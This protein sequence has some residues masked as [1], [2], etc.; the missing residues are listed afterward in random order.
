[1]ELRNSK[2]AKWT[3]DGWT[4]RPRRGGG[5]G[6]HTRRARYLSA[7]LSAIAEGDGG[8]AWAEAGSVSR[9]SVRRIP[10]AAA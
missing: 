1:M 6:E 7:N 5:A 8:S 4:V 10:T 2:H 3:V 9:R